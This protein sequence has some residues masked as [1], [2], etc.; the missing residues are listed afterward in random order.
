[1]TYKNQELSI[2]ISMPVLNEQVNIR[3]VLTQVAAELKSV[4][5]T[6]CIVDDG[7]KDGTLEIIEELI[8]QNN[9]IKLIERVKKGYGCQRGAASRIAL[10]WLIANTRHT[11]LVEMDADGSQRPIELLNGARQVFVLD[12][13]IAIASRYVYGS[14]VIGRSLRRRFVSIFYSFLA[15]LL[16]N[17]RIHDYSHCFRF[18]RREAA[19]L[20]LDFKPRYTSP[21]YLLEILVIW[22]T[23]GYRVI[24]IPT[25]YVERNDNGSKVVFR[26]VIKGFFGILYIALKFH[27]KYYLK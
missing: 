3:S 14:K 12:Y 17:H 24:E 25:F 26:D 23:N 2:G 11:V 10:E 4:N 20:L 16:F 7:S 21:M 13:D 6:I 1:M 27:R 8:T 19:K 9:S 22:I 15:R 18:Y 5:Y